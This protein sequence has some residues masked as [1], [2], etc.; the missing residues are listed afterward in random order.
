MVWAAAIFEGLE[1]G[2]VAV[3]NADL[4]VTGLLDAAAGQALWDTTSAHLRTWLAKY[5][6]S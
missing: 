5:N 3:I 2:G 1:P 6:A 4:D